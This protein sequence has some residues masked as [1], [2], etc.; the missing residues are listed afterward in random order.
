MKI[1]KLFKF[2]LLIALLIGAIESRASVPLNE[3]SG[4]TSIASSDTNEDKQDKDPLS[5]TPKVVFLFGFNHIFL[6]NIKLALALAYT[7]PL[8]LPNL[9][10]PNI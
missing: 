2:L 3:I 6:S 8:L 10:P 7:N 1:L 9:R 4:L 5:A